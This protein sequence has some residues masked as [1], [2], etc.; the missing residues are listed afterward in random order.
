MLQLP[1]HVLIIGAGKAA[2]ETQRGSERAGEARKFAL[3]AL[4]LMDQHGLGARLEGTELNERTR[5]RSK[6]GRQLG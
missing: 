4:G 2:H 3:D 5:R 1:P 6:E